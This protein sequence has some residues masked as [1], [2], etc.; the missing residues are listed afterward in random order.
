MSR[1]GAVIA[2]ACAALC[3]LALAVNAPSSDSRY[4]DSDIFVVNVNGAGR[5][6]LTRRQEPAQRVARA[7]SPDGR[8]LGLDR[9]RVEDGYGYWS[10]DVLPTRGG[11]ARRL[12]RL[13]DASAYGPAWSRDGRRIAFETC[14]HDHSVGVVR[15]D[16]RGL[17]SIPD[18]SEPTWLSR[19]QLAFLTDV[20]DLAGGIAI[21]RADGSRRR[22][23]VRAEDV[24]LS[25]VFG[26]A[27]SPNG[28]RVVFSAAD[29]YSTRIYSIGVARGASSELITDDGRDPSWSP[30]SRRL[31]FVLYEGQAATI[32]TVGA[33]GA[34]LRKF[35]RTR[36]LDPD[37]PSWSP[38]GRRIAFI[39]DAEG[40][41]KLVVLDVRRRSLRVV[42]RGVARQPIVWSPNGR[43]LYYTVPRA[44]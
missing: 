44:S 1:R 30:T 25:H 28:K 23:L 24:S 36:G 26:P 5:H 31:A 35:A 43:R 38:D 18:A 41:A 7:I 33:D 4:G 17:I 37:R 10:V 15:R 6:N 27:A 22:V 3:G 40:A 16:G 42:A 39:S 32:A 29:R 8:T 2:L 13:P 11:A 19:E 9:L 14:C 21:A 12:I 20:G 34:A